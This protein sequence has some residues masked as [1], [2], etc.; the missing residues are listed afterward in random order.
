MNFLDICKEVN[1]LSGLHGSFTDVNST[2]DL[3]TQ[4]AVGVSERW[5]TLQDDYD[6]TFMIKRHTTFTCTQGEEEY[7]PYNASP[8]V[9]DVGI[10]DLGLYSSIYEDNKKLVRVPWTSFPTIDNTVEGEPKWYAID[11]R[12][13]NLYL[14][15]PDTSYP[16]DIYYVKTV[17]DLFLTWNNT[18][19]TTANQ[20]IPDLPINYH[21][22]LVSMGLSS[23]F[24][25]IGDIRKEA[26][27]ELKYR[28]ELGT[29]MREYIASKRIKA[30]SFI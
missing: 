21:S 17:Q 8:S 20:A 27:W 4:I 10:Q 29:L 3:Q 25:F 26:R 22:I 28:E 13:N 6:W 1:K 11:D 16:F 18:A 2:K 24:N 15:L 23:F 9:Y 14:S 7:I 12:T 5:K 30:R 19:A